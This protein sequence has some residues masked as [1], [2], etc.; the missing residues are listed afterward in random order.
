MREK[1]H[2]IVLGLIL[3]LAVA[4]TG[5]L[6]HPLVLGPHGV[7]SGLEFGLQFRIGDDGVEWTAKLTLPG[8]RPL[9][10]AGVRAGPIETL[11]PRSEPLGFGAVRLL[12]RPALDAVLRFP[13]SGNAW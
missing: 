7:L 13:G 2:R 1:H 9:T 12:A 11:L 10:R 4:A 6:V 5:L 8:D 3:V